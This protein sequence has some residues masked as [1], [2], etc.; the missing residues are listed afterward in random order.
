MTHLQTQRKRYL[1]R[2]SP[3]SLG[4]LEGNGWKKV[5]AGQW[6]PLF[7]NS[8]PYW[9]IVL[10]WFY[11]E[12]MTSLACAIWGSGL[13]RFGW[14]LPVSTRGKTKEKQIYYLNCSFLIYVGIAES[15]ALCCRLQSFTCLATHHFKGAFFFPRNPSYFYEAIL[16]FPQQFPW[17]WFA[18]GRQ[19]LVLI[20]N[21]GINWKLLKSGL[22][23][24]NKR[25]DCC[26][27]IKVGYRI[28]FWDV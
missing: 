25:Q 2:L 15:E 19:Q 8:P 7:L 17:G 13:Q 3:I 20:C 5:K 9:G 23:A 18:G 10:S 6:L 12:E 11:P 14:P 27:R 26:S 4:S 1:S 22:W 24:E 16:C 28:V 21:L